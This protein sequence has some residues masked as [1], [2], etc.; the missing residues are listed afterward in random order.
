M[1]DRFGFNKNSLVVEIASND[2]YLLQYFKEKQIP[3]LGIE[4]TE[5]TAKVAREKG[6]ESITEFFGESFAKN[7][8]L[9]IEKRICCWAIMC[10]RMC[11]TSTTLSKV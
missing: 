3:V 4:P 2:G 7:W 5:S 11:P 9:K 8:Q 1:I 6:I 10:L